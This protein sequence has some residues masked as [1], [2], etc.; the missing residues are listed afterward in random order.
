MEIEGVSPE[1]IGN[2]FL[3]RYAPSSNFWIVDRNIIRLNNKISQYSEL[4]RDLKT[5][6]SDAMHGTMKT[7]YLYRNKQFRLNSI[8]QRQVYRFARYISASDRQY[9]ESHFRW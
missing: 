7:S 9:R 2:L 8:L 1:N 3:K 4:G 6:I 5:L